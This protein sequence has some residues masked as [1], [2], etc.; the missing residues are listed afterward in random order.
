MNLDHHMSATFP[1]FNKC[2]AAAKA[3]LIWAEI[4]LVYHEV[5]ID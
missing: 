3:M 4:S 2:V 1:I 5:L